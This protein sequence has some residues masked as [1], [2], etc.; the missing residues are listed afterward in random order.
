VLF[1]F[2]FAVF[3]LLLGFAAVYD[4]NQ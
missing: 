3:G 4:K 1:I 2:T